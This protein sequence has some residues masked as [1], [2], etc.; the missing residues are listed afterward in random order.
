[1]NEY[2]ASASEVLSGA[3]QDH[4]V[5]VLIG[6]TTFGKGLVQTIR[7]PFKEGDVVKLTTAKYFTPKG[8]DINKK[9]V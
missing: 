3:I 5:G 1:V 8:R 7:G 9:G 6:H 4:G 2:S